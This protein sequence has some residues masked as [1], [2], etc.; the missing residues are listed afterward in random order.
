MV[1][2]VEDCALMLTQMTGYDPL[3]IFS[4]QYTC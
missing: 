3:D 4:A 2:T 1:C